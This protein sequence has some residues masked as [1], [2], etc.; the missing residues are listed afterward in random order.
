[1]LRGTFLIALLPLCLRPGEPGG[2]GGGGGARRRHRG[3]RALGLS[4]HQE[5]FPSL[6]TWL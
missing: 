4:L 3:E 2:R 6:Q 5:L 1:M